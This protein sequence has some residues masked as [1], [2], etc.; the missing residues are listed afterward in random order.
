MDKHLIDLI[1]QGLLPFRMVELPAFQKFVQVLQ[2]SVNV[3]SR[4]AVKRK[5][6]QE[7]E[8]MKMKI[9]KGF[10]SIDY[11]ATTTDCWTARRR[12]FI[13]LTHIGLTPPR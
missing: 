9:K 4:P 3:I 1:C 5:L 6:A 8:S 2:P 10:S 13:G 7:A 12:S 11:V